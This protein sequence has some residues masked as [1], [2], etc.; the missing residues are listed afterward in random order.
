[1]KKPRLREG[2]ELGPHSE[3][4]GFVLCQPSKAGTILPRIPFS[5]W[6]WVRAGH[7]MNLHEIW[8]VEVEHSHVCTQ[9]HVGLGTC[10]C[11]PPAASPSAWG[12]QV[13]HM[14]HLQTPLDFLLLLVQT[15][16]PVCV[17]HQGEVGQFYRLPHHRRSTPSSGHPYHQLEAW[18]QWE[19]NQVP[20]R[21]RCGSQG[22]LL[23]G[24]QVI[25]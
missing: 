9:V 18:R 6:F 17:Q 5:T 19:T 24:P 22:V 7:K 14:W 1:M 25:P 11:H 10:M 20:V 2:Q 15:L 8:K 16:G 13:P 21:H 23:V 12:Q 3:Y 4:R